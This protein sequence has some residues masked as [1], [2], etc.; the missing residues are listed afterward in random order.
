MTPLPNPIDEDKRL[1][2]DVRVFDPDNLLED[3]LS[4]SEGTIFCL[5]ETRHKNHEGD[6]TVEY[7]FAQIY[8]T[9]DAPA[10][11]DNRS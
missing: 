10:S 9:K 6:D 11:K 5:G 8:K 2:K 7:T 1:F 4:S 3:M